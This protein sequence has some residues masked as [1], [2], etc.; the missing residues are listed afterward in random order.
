MIAFAASVAGTQGQEQPRERLRP[1]VARLEALLKAYTT[2][3]ALEQPEAER[4]KYWLLADTAVERFLTGSFV[5]PRAKALEELEWIREY[6]RLNRD[7]PRDG[8]ARA[9]VLMKSLSLSRL[10]LDLLMLCA[11][12]DL[13]F[14]FRHWFQL[15]QSDP[16]RSHLTVWRALDILEPSFSNPD[17][18][19]DIF[20]P[21]GTLRRSCLMSL[22]RQNPDEGVLGGVA[23]VDERIVGHLLGSDSFDSRLSGLLTR[24]DAL[25][26][27]ASAADPSLQVFCEHVKIKAF[28][29]EPMRV[30]LQSVDSRRTVRA[31]WSLCAAARQPLLEFD[32]APAL[33]VGSPAW[34]VL[35]ELAL[36]EARL[37]E[38]VLL[39]RN[40]DALVST[41][42]AA[43]LSASLAASLAAH[44]G[45]TVV[46][47][48]TAAAAA[49][50]PHSIF[51]PILLAAPSYEDRVTLWK[52]PLT[53]EV[54]DA[55][56]LASQLAGSFLLTEDQI[57]SALE[58]AR[59]L[60]RRDR[61]FSGSLTSE[62]LFEACRHQTGKRLVAMAQRLEPRPGLRLDAVVLP[63]PNFRQLEELRNRIRHRR[64][65]HTAMGYDHRLRLGRG[66]M[67]LFAGPSGTGKTMAA[68]VLASERSCDLYKVDL[69]SVVSKWVGE[70]EKNLNRIFEE[71]EH[72]QGMLF[73]DEADALF[74][75]RGEVKEARDRW[76]NLEVNFLLQRIE[77]FSGVVI[78][79]TNLRSNIDPAFSRR[80]HSVVD[81]PQPDEHARLAIWKRTL[82]DE[83]FVSLDEREM[84][85]IAARFELSGGMIRNAVLDASYRALEDR[86]KIGL[87][88]VT[89]AAARE[90]QKVGRPVTQSEFGETLYRIALEEVL[91]PVRPTGRD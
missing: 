38:V 68:E 50:F 14:R 60:A 44:R 9:T 47:V 51:I 22:E 35:V 42:Q 34:S 45:I 76:A 65:V 11:L 64:Q 40:A 63:P 17:A 74:G 5:Q 84:R 87:R 52:K 54:P 20:H 37:S 79:A 2:R 27:R 36:R 28:S 26:A 89:A 78:L 8:G 49:I 23:H 71:A 81:F 3:R 16:T 29:G 41:E 86:A 61:P 82:P 4:E 85:L 58:A 6:E 59:N 21:E 90:Y 32:C 10:E 19:R 55:D 15:I 75:Q 53:A 70:T 73:F 25:A 67:A 88:Q 13:D 18:A 43:A 30:L 57:E 48:S 39:F 62:V 91:A 33:Q 80:F 66:L 12:P 69:S 1:E 72:C 77:E 7:N 56:A 24:S 83:E 46:E 31:A